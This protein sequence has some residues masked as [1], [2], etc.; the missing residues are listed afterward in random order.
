MAMIRKQLYVAS[1][2]QR[3]LRDLAARWRCTEAEVMRRALDRLPEGQASMDQ[4]LRE[5][6]LLVPPATDPT[7]P[8]GKALRALEREVED[9][10]EQAPPLELT[11]AVLQDRR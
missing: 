1:E 11:H 5:A 3:K 6:G 4:R 7:I 9:W 2:H 8:T 10:L